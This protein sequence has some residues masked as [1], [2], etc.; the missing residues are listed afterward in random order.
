MI[1]GWSECFRLNGQAQISVDPALCFNTDPIRAHLSKVKLT[2]PYD[3]FTDFH[4]RFFLDLPAFQ[5][6]LSV[7]SFDH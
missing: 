3:L 4:L 2:Y 1:P 7:D 5:F 6:V